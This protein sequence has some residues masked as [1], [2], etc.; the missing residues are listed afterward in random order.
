MHQLNLNAKECILCILSSQ[1]AIL[2]CCS[3]F[4]NCIPKDISLAQSLLLIADSTTS[5]HR[6]VM[7]ISSSLSSKANC[8][9]FLKPAPHAVPPSQ[10]V[11][12]C[13]LPGP[14]WCPWGSPLLTLQV[15]WDPPSKYLGWDDCPHQHCCPLG[16]ATRVTDW[17]SLSTHGWLCMWLWTLQSYSWPI[18]NTATNMSLLKCKSDASQVWSR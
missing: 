6:Y 10:S 7:D 3:E 4:W 14:S 9:F 16:L 18:F 2:S 1:S 17:L 8:S 15:H 11:A 5:P 12:I 13:T